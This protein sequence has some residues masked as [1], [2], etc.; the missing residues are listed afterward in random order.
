MHCCCERGGYDKIRVV[1]Y[2]SMTTDTQ[3][4]NIES[5]KNRDSNFSSIHSITI[6]LQILCQGH[7]N[8]PPWLRI[9]LSQGFP[10]P[11]TRTAP[12][13]GE[14]IAQAR[15]GLWSSILVPHTR[16]AS[17]T[18]PLVSRVDTAHPAELIYCH[19]VCGCAA[20]WQSDP[21]VRNELPSVILWWC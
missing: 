14:D 1:C 7:K 13:I 5:Y 8:A 19:E 9:L 3:H 11:A 6:F 20:E 16:C 17:R 4:I 12:Q 18:L 2:I 10:I 15:S 21:P